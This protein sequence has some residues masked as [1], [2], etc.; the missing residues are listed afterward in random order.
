MATFHPVLNMRELR[1]Q[2]STKSALLKVLNDLLLVLLV[3]SAVFDTVNHFILLKC[4]EQY[5]GI[6]GTALKWFLS[7]LKDR[8]FSVTIEN[9]TSSSA[10]RTCG[11][12]Q[13][14]ILGPVQ[15]SLYLPP[16]ASIFDKH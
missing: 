11:V 5:V 6:K 1:A 9:F 4:L 10:T 7:Y 3:Q 13:G 12:P 15:F 14:F 8:T 16:L 2:Y